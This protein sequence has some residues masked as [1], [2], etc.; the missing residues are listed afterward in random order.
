M[1]KTTRGRQLGLYLS[2]LF[3][4]CVI[5]P[6]SIVIPLSIPSSRSS[7]VDPMPLLTM[8]QSSNL[9][10][11]PDMM[12]SV[13]DVFQVQSLVINNG[14]VPI[15][16]VALVTSDFSQTVCEPQ[17]M[18]N[19]IGLMNP[20]DQ[21]SCI[22]IRMIDAFDLASGMLGPYEFFVT[23]IDNATI[24]TNSTVETITLDVERNTELSIM[25]D[26]NIDLGPDEMLSEN[27]IITVFTKFINTGNET[28]LNVTSRFQ[29]L[30]S[31]APMNQVMYSE[32]YT[33]SLVDIQAGGFQVTESASAFGVTTLNPIFVNE[34]FF[35]NTTQTTF[36]AI[37]ATQ[38]FSI[39]RMFGCSS[40]GDTVSVT[41]TVENSGT[42]TLTNVLVSDT[43]LT[44]IIC[45]SMNVD[46][47]IGTMLPGQVETCVSTY[48]T[49]TPDYVTGVL[50]SN[51]TVT[52]TRFTTQ[53]VFMDTTPN[54]I[55]IADGL[56]VWFYVRP[57][58]S[59][60]GSTT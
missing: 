51:F 32:N 2:L 40:P 35:A 18:D 42:E 54:T 9:F 3:L 33:I 21:F 22:S 7:N 16:N 4:I 59:T 13:G 15:P 29:V 25:F 28:L 45:S 26:Q 1:K 17:L 11:G 48:L 23:G 19:T 55:Q 10:L 39:A 43:V 44:P 6:L 31:L 36:S 60:P 20:A 52:G 34:T 47:A 53:T 14:N 49:T 38:E 41:F 37:N 46:N 8:N 27:D 56:N 30:P 12:L 58:F 57:H 50:N 5:V 24:A